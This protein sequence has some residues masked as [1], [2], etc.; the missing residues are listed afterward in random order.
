V[1]M[2]DIKIIGMTGKGNFSNY[3]GIA[4]LSIAGICAPYFLPYRSDRYLLVSV[5]L[6]IIAFLSAVWQI[7]R[8]NV[9][10]RH[11]LQ[12][13]A[14]ALLALCSYRCINYLFPQF[15]PYLE[16][17]M[18][19]GFVYV[20]TLS[21]WNLPLATL[22]GDELY[23]PKTM[24]GKIIFRTILLIAPLGLIAVWLGKAAADGSKGLMFIPGVL[25]FYLA[26][27]IPF[28][29]LSQYSGWNSQKSSKIHHEDSSFLEEKPTR[30]DRIAREKK[31][32]TKNKK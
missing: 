32:S 20:H 17:F 8:Q 13:S 15:S 23:A 29:A 14:S 28:P 11:F 31:T 18:I 24:A 5:L 25:G 30:K 6:G 19:L 22:I 21:F 27:S 9:Y 10:T 2:K 12:I 3:V 7:R 4:I 1:K 26:Y 16:L